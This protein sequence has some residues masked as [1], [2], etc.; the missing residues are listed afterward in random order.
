MEHTERVGTNNASASESS[1]SKE[2]AQVDRVEISNA[3]L[4]VSK[5]Q[6]AIKREVEFARR[7]LYNVPPMSKERAE[8]LL[9]SLDQG[10]Y[11]APDVRMKLSQSLTADIAPGFAPEAGGKAESA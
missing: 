11:N 10:A 2:A 8:S 7:A 3:A 9:K 1:S 5:E 4:E 6:E